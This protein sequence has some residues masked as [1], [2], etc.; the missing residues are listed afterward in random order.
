MSVRNR[1]RRLC[2]S[3]GHVILLA[4]VI[5]VG[6]TRWPHFSLPFASRHDNSRKSCL[7]LSK[8]QAARPTSPSSSALAMAGLP[9]VV[10]GSGAG[11]VTG[12]D[13][14]GRKSRIGESRRASY[15]R[16]FLTMF[17]P[18]IVRARRSHHR[19]H[20]PDCLATADAVIICV[21]TPLNKSKAPD[22]G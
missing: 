14:I 5:A 22:N 16:T 7:P 18:R 4:L 6:Q 8:I 19:H 11:S 10:G 12:Y 13:K 15:I 20:H 9:L 21:P 3:D 1:W 2:R 17:W